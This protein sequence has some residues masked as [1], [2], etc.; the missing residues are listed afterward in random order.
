MGISSSIIKKEYFI[1]IYSFETEYS[2]SDLSPL[3]SQNNVKG[4]F[5]IVFYYK[6]FPNI[7]HYS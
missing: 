7:I 5:T 2:V 4:F 3:T 6:K 1:S